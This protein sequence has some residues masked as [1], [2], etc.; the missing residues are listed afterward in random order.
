MDSKPSAAYRPKNQVLTL[1]YDLENLG[2]HISYFSV[3]ATFAA[4][5]SDLE[6][7]MALIAKDAAEIQRLIQQFEATPE[8]E[9]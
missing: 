2:H 7:Y 9:P 5:Q 3:L 4:S 8:V 1:L 6:H